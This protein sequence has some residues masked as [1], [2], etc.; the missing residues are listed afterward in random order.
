[1]NTSH[2]FL[3]GELAV[4]TLEGSGPG[5]GGAR[6]KAVCE[7]VLLPLPSGCHPFVDA[8]AI[9]VKKPQIPK[10]R[11]YLPLGLALGSPIFP[12]GCEGKLG[13]ALESLQGLRD[14]T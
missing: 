11:V 2:A 1:M 12:S 13:V 7:V 3:Q 8:F 10:H 5:E 6:T 4:T 14:L 9:T